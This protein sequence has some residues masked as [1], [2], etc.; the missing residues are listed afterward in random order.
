[1]LLDAVTSLVRHFGPFRAA[2]VVTLTCVVISG[3]VTALTM[4]ALEAS[5]FP[6]LYLATLT[7]LGLALPVTYLTHLAVERADRAQQAI[8]KSEQ[9]ARAAQT[10]LRDAIEGFPGRFALFDRDDQLL[11]CNQRHRE[12]YPE[13]AELMIPGVSFA[14]LVWAA[15]ERNVVRGTGPPDPYVEMRLHRRRQKSSPPEQQ[16]TDGRWVLVSEQGTRNGQTVVV[17]TDITQFK[18]ASEALRESEERFFQV[19]QSSPAMICIIDAQIHRFFDVNETWLN[20]FGFERDEV[21]GHTSV[22]TGLWTDPHLHQILLDTLR[23][24]G[25]VLGFV[26][27]SRTPNGHLID[28]VISGE[29]LELDGRPHYLLVTEDVL[30]RKRVDRLKNEFIATVSHEIRTPLTSIGGSLSLLTGG[31]A[32]DMPESAQRQLS[33]AETNSNRLVRLVNDILDLEK[34][35]SGEMLFRNQTI[36]LNA[37]AEQALT[38]NQAYGDPYGVRFKFTHREPGAT[39]NADRDRLDQVFANL[40]SNAAK[41]SPRDGDV[42]VTVSRHNGM[43]RTAVTDHGPGIPEEFRDRIYEK[44]TQADTSDARRIK[45]TGLGLNIVKQIVEQMDGVVGCEPNTSEGTTIYFD[46]PDSQAH[47]SAVDAHATGD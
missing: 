30:E 42:E 41:F 26:Q 4:A 10:M 9:D 46:L 24:D 21:I 34:I 5:L 27:Q 11:L 35:E 28:C 37:V 2:L 40:L 8:L 25:R 29:T 1:M 14:E 15:A 16:M 13:I 18:R 32:G 44:F 20:V 7:P 43:I 6:A 47:D 3:L 33:I 12:M 17:R 31:A 39:V 38:I 22:E 45:G 36:Q 19:F 23:D